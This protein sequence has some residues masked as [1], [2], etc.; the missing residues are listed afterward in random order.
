MQ[1]KNRWYQCVKM[2]NLYTF[3]II[4][5]EKYI[6]FEFCVFEPS[7]IQN[8]IL[9]R[10]LFCVIL[11][12]ASIHSLLCVLLSFNFLVIDY[13]HS[14]SRPC[15]GE[16]EMETGS[17]VIAYFIFFI[18][19]HLSFL[20]SFRLDSHLWPETCSD[21]SLVSCALLEYF[22]IMYVDKLRKRSQLSE[23]RRSW[24]NI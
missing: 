1:K 2:M 12:F 3:H 17:F 6:S 18:A 4:S 16:T 24:D 20:N 5:M 10:T 9:S 15:F 14:F 11:L 13:S 8:T 7:E 21:G 22:I 19:F 23:A